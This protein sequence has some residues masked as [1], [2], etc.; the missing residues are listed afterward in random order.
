MMINAVRQ[1]VS[2]SFARRCFF[3][4]SYNKQEETILKEGALK[5]IPSSQ[6]LLLSEL[7]LN[8]RILV[9]AESAQQNVQVTP[10]CASLTQPLRGS[11]K[12]VLQDCTFIKCPG[13]DQDSVIRAQMQRV[14]IPDDLCQPTKASVDLKIS[15]KETQI[16][17]KFLWLTIELLKIAV[18]RKV[19]K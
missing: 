3:L 16:W 15:K 1:E 10:S 12:T 9:T 5:P 11:Q 6:N 19:S 17:L 8:I 7:L 4:G 13:K 18:Q 2:L 14:E